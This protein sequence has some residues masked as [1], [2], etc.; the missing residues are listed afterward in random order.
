MDKKITSDIC[1][2]KKKGLLLHPN[3]PQRVK[4]WFRSEAHLRDLTC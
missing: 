3:F 2:A 1:T 4:K